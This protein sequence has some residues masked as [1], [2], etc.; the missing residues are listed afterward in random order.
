MLIG[1][2][3]C[4]SF[5]T[6]S[7]SI[8]EM[9][10]LR[11]AGHDI[12][13]IMSESAAKTDTRFGTAA[14]ITDR[15]VHITG[16]GIIHTIE[17]AEPLGPKIK[18]DLLIISPCTGNT[19]AKLAHGITDTAVTMAAK[20]HSRQDRP[21]LIALA[22]NDAMSANL[23]NIGRMMQK[24]SVYFVPMRQDDPVK[25]PHSLVAD[26][27]RTQECVDAAM[28]GKQIYPVFL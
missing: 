28:V 27:E 8:A 10:K 7:E 12:I 14:E 22:T 19:I 25:K 26:F 18:L 6:L 4:G 9:E 15:I 20:A 16:R 21:I 1:W 13:P 17:K 24:K 23:E 2:A 11:A 3:F 5:C